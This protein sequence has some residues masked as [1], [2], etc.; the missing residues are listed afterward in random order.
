MVLCKMDTPRQL[1]PLGYVE[2]FPRDEVDGSRE[3]LLLIF[4]PSFDGEVDIPN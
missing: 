1:F 4:P 2:I 3:N